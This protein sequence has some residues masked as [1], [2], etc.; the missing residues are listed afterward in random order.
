M[1]LKAWIERQNNLVLARFVAVGTERAPAERLCQG[2]SEAVRWINQQATA[3][4]A[5]T[6]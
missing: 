5:P 2:E 6:E 4:D 3:L 1:R